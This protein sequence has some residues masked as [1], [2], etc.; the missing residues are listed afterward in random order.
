MDKTDTNRIMKLRELAQHS[1]K[2][3]QQL[4]EVEN[5]CQEIMMVDE[6]LKEYAKLENGSE[7]LF[8]ISNGIFAKAKVDDNLKLIVNV[9]S[10]VAVEKSIG[11]SRELLAKHLREIMELRDKI[12]ASIMKIQEKAREIE[13]QV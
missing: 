4:S 8:P 11:D 1:K 2:M 13:E 12:A 10:G 9:G 5:Q 3:K 7:I 6:S